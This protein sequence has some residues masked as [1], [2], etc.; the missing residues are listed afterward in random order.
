MKHMITAYGALIVFILNT[1]MCITVSNATAA[2]A[3]AKEYKAQVVAEI[4][5]S[6]FNE[7]VINACITQ[8]QTEGYQISI[9]NCIYDENYNIQ[10]AEVILTY[11]YNLPLFGISETKTSRGIAR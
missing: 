2:M 9:T 10:T 3:E 8:A 1:F 6:N 11:S 4:E 5:N 7:N